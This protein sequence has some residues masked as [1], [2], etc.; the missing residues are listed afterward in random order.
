M[1]TKRKNNWLTQ[2]SSWYFSKRVLP[3]WC[4]LLMDAVI[5]FLSCVFVYW[6]QN[7]TMATFTHRDGVFLTSLVYALLSWVGARI[8]EPI[9]AWCATPARWTCS[10]SPMPT[11]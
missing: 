6:V 3:Y 1:S 11:R 9:R 8:S 2:L 5:V 10:A 7:R 4:L